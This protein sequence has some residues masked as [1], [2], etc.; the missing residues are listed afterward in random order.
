[1]CGSAEGAQTLKNL[2]RVLLLV[3]VDGEEGVVLL[4]VE[5]RGLTGSQ[6]M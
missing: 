6:E 3:E 1:V 2:R 4:Q 5:R